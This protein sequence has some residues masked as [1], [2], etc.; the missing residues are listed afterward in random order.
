MI[1][2]VVPVVKYNC[3]LTFAKHRTK[4]DVFL[5]IQ[6]LN[7][8]SWHIILGGFNHSE[9]KSVVSFFTAWKSRRVGIH[10]LLSTMWAAILE[11][12]IDNIF[13]DF[14]LFC[15]LIKNLKFDYSYNY[16]GNLL[17]LHN[18]EEKNNNL[19]Y[20]ITKYIQ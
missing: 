1:Y 11:R 12:D 4:L 8:L 20:P 15:L 3:S 14:N 16:Y 9:A 18:K 10:F 19:L 7:I 6:Q 2:S 17:K 5:N 13:S